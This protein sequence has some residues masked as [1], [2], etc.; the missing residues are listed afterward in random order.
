LG[1]GKRTL[2]DAVSDDKDDCEQRV[3]RPIFA[4]SDLKGMFTKLNVI[5]LATFY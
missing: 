4:R 2:D 3:K 1:T 5:D